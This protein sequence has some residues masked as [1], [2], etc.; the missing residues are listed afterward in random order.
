[1]LQVLLYSVPV[2]VLFELLPVTVPTDGENYLYQVRAPVVPGTGSRYEGVRVVVGAWCCCTNAVM[3][4]MC[5][6]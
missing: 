5:V 6:M 2:L 4:V 1:M 3:C